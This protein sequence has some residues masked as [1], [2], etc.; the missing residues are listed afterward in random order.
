MF[1]YY[2]AIRTKKASTSIFVLF[3]SLADFKTHGFSSMASLWTASLCLAYWV[4]WGKTTYLLSFFVR[5]RSG[6]RMPGKFI[7]KVLNMAVGARW[8]VGVS[9]T[10]KLLTDA[11]ILHVQ[12]FK[13]ED[14]LSEGL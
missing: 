13:V 8:V 6:P 2:Q 3:C 12:H 11:N 4:F 10:Y 9:H 1:H 14:L 5:Q 7:S